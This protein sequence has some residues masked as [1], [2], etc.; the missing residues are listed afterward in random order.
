M[1]LKL[2][3]TFAFAFSLLVIMLITNASALV[4]SNVDADVL[5]PG[6]EG[7]L[8]I[9]VK[10]NLDNDVEDVSLALDFSNLPLS[11]TDSSEETID[12]IDDGDKETFSFRIRAES[13]AKTGDYKIPYTLT[14]KNASSIQE[15]TLSV[16]VSAKPD[17]SFSVSAENQIIGQKGKITLKIINKGLGEAKF[18]SVKA[19]ANGF[20]LV[21]EN[22]VYIGNI[23]SD[24]FDTAIFDVLFKSK[25]PVFSALVEYKDIDNKAYSKN[26]EM[27]I[28]AYTTEEAIQQGLLKKSKAFL[29]IIAIAILIIIWLIWR[30]IRKRRRMQKSREAIGN[31][32]R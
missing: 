28:T 31:N 19:F 25:N 7:R 17:I 26:I 20:A 21:S 12:E 9:I 24:D 2:L 22:E 13:N 6:Q 1:K 16:R 10:N 27:P 30:A 18:V 32:R 8:S 15:G 4:I 23:D 14:Y 3:S 5:M 29:Y 11:A